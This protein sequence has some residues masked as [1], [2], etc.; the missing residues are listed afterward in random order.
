MRPRLIVAFGFF[1]AVL[2]ASGC[3][4]FQIGKGRRK[5]VLV[6]YAEGRVM[7]VNITDRLTGSKEMLFVSMPQKAMFLEGYIHGIV[8]DY[9]DNPIQGV[10]VRAVAE[11]EAREG[12]KAFQS[13]AFDAGVT[14]SNGVYRIRFSLPVL[15][16]KVDVRGKLVYNPGWE[17]EKV[18]LGKAYEPQIKE[19]PFRM[20]FDE[21]RGLL[22]FA[23][24]IRKAIVRAVRG[25]LPA[26]TQAPEAKPTLPEA[27]KEAPPEK[28]KDDEFFRNLN[29]GP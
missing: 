17:Q 18:N 11:G 7:D 12:A 19:S 22:V 26:K 3:G 10:V 4:Q 8:T 20:I 1:L 27:K 15:D 28:G 5:V 13:S 16:R 6:D 21:R 29:F 14:D 25:D 9:D 23:E 24:G 2:G